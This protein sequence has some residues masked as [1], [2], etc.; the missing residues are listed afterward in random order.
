MQN[1]KSIYNGKVGVSISL[2]KLRRRIFEGYDSIFVM[3]E[4]ENYNKKFLKVLPKGTYVCVR[5]NGTHEES[6][7]YYEKLL[8]YIENKGYKMLE[9][10]VEITLID[11][12]LTNKESEIVTEI[13]ILVDKY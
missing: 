8:K 6:T 3:I 11:F 5:F 2:E 9:D 1:E 13:Q 12:G 7:L 10:S 4:G